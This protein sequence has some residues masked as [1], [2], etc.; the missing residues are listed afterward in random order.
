MF[1]VIGKH[2]DNDDNDDNDVDDDDDDDDGN[3][4]DECLIIKIY[5]NSSN[6]HLP[7]L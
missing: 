4:D 1:N 7:N 6:F 3:D 5:N 2:D